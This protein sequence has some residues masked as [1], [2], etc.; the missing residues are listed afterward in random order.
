MNLLLLVLLW[1]W[2]PCAVHAQTPADSGALGWDSIPPDTVCLD[3]RYIRPQPL[4][5][6]SPAPDYPESAKLAFPGP[7]GTAAPSVS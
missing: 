5:A 1:V 3:W 2:L 7:E 4:P 6:S